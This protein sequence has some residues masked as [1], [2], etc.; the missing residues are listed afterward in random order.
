MYE[1][2]GDCQIILDYLEPKGLGALQLALEQ[3]KARLAAE[4]LFDSARKRPLPLFPRSVGIVTSLSGAALH[5]MLT[6]L[7]RRCP[8][9]SI[10]IAP[11]QVQG[12]RSARQIAEAIRSVNRLGHVDV[13]IVGRGGGSLEDLWSFN[14]EIVVR[15]ITA[16]QIPVVSAVGHETDV[17]LADL[18]ADVRAP[19]PSAA[20]EAVAPVLD[21]LMGRLLELGERHR[22]AIA[23]RC[24]DERRRL[25]FSFS[26][27]LRLRLLVQEG[28]QRVDVA[29]FAMS[30]AV[31]GILRQGWGRMT[32]VKQEL[33]RR[34]PQSLVRQG[35]AVLPQM[36]DRLRQFMHHRLDRSRRLTESRFAE[37]HHLSPL[38]VLGRGYSIVQTSPGRQVVRDARQ[39]PV[40]DDVLARL[41][42]GSL[43][44][45]VKQALEET[46]FKSLGDRL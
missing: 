29:V 15:A 31:H 40:G 27:L 46:D 22:H 38:A 12:E 34:N 20:A 39:V 24:A 10:V 3:L 2:R 23:R 37:L 6:V 44:C 13:L 8:I 42:R 16:S 26:R 4:G 25:Q 18:A 19:T 35:L 11:V 9:L 41:A 36:V 17:T 45:V 33:L 32:G 14:E 1:S 28:A 5:D 43:L 30:H 21:D 7:H